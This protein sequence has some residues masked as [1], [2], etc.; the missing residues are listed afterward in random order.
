MCVHIFK[1]LYNSIHNYIIIYIIIYKCVY[2]YDHIHK[3]TC[4]CLLLLC[5]NVNEKNQISTLFIHLDVFLSV[6]INILYSKCFCT[7]HKKMPKIFKFNI[8]LL[9]DTF[10]VSTSTLLQALLQ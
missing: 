2:L 9:M 4:I 7:L 8:A 1:V 5:F 10:N 6:Y 3:Y